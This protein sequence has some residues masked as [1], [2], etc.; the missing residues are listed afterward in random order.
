VATQPQANMQPAV[1]PIAPSPWEAFA[2]LRTALDAEE[3]RLRAQRQS[4][5]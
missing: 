5:T 4:R 2:V 3:R 1:A